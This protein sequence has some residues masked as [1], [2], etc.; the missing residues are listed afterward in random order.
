MHVYKHKVLT[1]VKLYILYDNYKKVL[2]NVKK[3]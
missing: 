1:S 3:M 2:K